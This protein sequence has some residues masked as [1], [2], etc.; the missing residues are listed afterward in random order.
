MRKYGRVDQNQK[1]LVDLMRTLGV[2]VQSLAD[3]GDGCPDLLCGLLGLT[4]IVEVKTEKGKLTPDQELWARVWNGSPILIL[5]TEEMVV[6]LVS[7]IRRHRR[8]PAQG[9]LEESRP[10]PRGNGA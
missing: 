10:A 2:S 6:R 5:R 9:I 4:F 8:L 3:V 1:V 7:Y